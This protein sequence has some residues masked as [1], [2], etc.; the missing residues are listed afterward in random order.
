[1]ILAAL[2]AL[3]ALQRT[4][5]PNPPQAGTAENTSESIEIFRRILADQ[6]DEAFQ[7]P[8]PDKAE[9]KKRVGV[10]SL[11]Q[12]DGMVTTLWAGNQTVSNSRGFHAPG[13]GA[14][15][16]LDVSLPVV[17]QETPSKPR[18][19]EP[20][21]DDEWESV[22]KQVRSGS[23]G[24]FHFGGVMADNRNVE[25][26]PQ[27][28]DKA[29]E[30]V[31]RTIARHAS[32]L[33]GLSPQDSITVAMHV[34][35]RNNVFWTDPDSQELH[36]LGTPPEPEEEGDEQGEMSRVYS[37][38]LAGGAEATEQHLV[39]RTTVGELQGLGEGDYQR[40]LQRAQ[41]NRY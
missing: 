16:V 17:T 14:L 35:G 13:L 28:I 39:I 21:R 10:S 36:G 38:V 30:A 18:G 8:D 22:R 7:K 31:L 5:A 4:P 15:F 23:E 20:A 27:A 34:S 2:L 40:L 11:F 12:R 41:I 32:R 26:D 29:T 37:M 25:I 3:T 9:K 33:E 19:S 6:I 1:M 24:G